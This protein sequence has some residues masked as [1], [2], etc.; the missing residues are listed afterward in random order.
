MIIAI[1][2]IFLLF[3]YIILIA[4]YRKYW[5]RIENYKIDKQPLP[6]QPYLSVIIAARN[7]ENNIGACLNALIDQHYPIDNFEIIV[8]ND[9]STDAT[10]AV[11]KSFD[12][13]NIILL[14]LADY[15]DGKPLNSYKKKSIETALAIAKGE[16]IVTTDADCIARPYWLQSI[17]DFYRERKPVYI[18]MPVA[19][20]LPQKSSFLKKFFYIFQA[21]DF[22]ALQGITGA[23]AAT[24]VH[25]MCNG[26]NLA[27]TKDSFYAVNGFDEIQDIASGDDMLLMEKIQKSFPDKISY[28]KSQEVIVTTHPSV[29]VGEF[30]HQRIR[31]AS[32]ADRY[33]DKKITAVLV[34]VYFLNV[35]LL[36]LAIASFFSLQAM[37][38]LLSSVFI[39]IIM[40]LFF[41]YPVARFFKNEKLLWWFIPCQPFHIFYTVIAGWLGK[42]GNYRW[43]GRNVK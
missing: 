33:T 23:S 20:S 41:L 8:T 13:P 3:P 5:L 34:W 2:T 35:W 4:Y 21:L 16:L 22:M 17:A 10:A 6:P 29:T 39:K 9:H 40:E 1:I 42:F 18:A 19:Y 37:W 32:K 31:W 11:V 25:N 43:K 28:L 14:E 15:I 27:Y 36:T 26:A 30:F 38:W 12:R 24:G 7:E